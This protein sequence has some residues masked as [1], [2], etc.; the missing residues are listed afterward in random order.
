MSI[1]EIMIFEENEIG[2]YAS[3]T[4]SETWSAITPKGIV[5]KLEQGEVIPVT[6]MKS[7]E[8]QNPS[9]V[10]E[11]ETSTQINYVLILNH[12]GQPF[13]IAISDGNGTPCTITSSTT[14]EMSTD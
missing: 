13:D 4:S 9:F 3:F 8:F 1:R 5:G 12:D 10:L 6:L 7:S 2:K 11:F 14:T